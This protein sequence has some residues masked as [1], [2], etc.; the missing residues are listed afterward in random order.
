MMPTL[1]QITCNVEWSGSKLPLHE[2][3]TVYA[4]G[5]VETYVAV[6]S[7]PTPFSIH[8]RSHGYIAPGLAMFVYMDGDYQCNRNRSNLKIPSEARTWKQTEVDFQVRQ[9]EELMPDGS[10][11]GKQWRF[12]PLKSSE[13]RKIL[14]ICR[15][16]YLPIPSITMRQY[17]SPRMMLNTLEQ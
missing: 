16:T 12:E 15:L 4:D 3:Q 9:K 10:F 2:Y 13:F 1:K 7:V 6:P 8:L 5:Y 17:V 14:E 11:S